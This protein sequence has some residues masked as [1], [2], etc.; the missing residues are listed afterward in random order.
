MET[1]QLFEDIIGLPDAEAKE[2]F[3]RLVG[4]DEIKERLIKEARILLNPELLEEWSK[5]H[6]KKVI[7][8]V[9][10]FQDRASLFI[11]AGDIG[12]GKTTL[13]E[14][15]GD[16]VARQE[17][18][19]VTL[20][21][22]SLNTR[23]R[24]AVGEMTRLISTAFDK[25][26]EVASERSSSGKKPSSAVIFVIDEADAL[27]QS[28]ELDQMHHED[29]AGVNAVIRGIDSLAPAHLPVLIIMCTNRLSAIDPAVMRRAAT[30]F[31]FNRP[32]DEQRM[33]ILRRELAET[34]IK[35]EELSQ[36]AKEMGAKDGKEYGFTYSDI[37][38]KFL[39]TLLLEAFPD[40][41][42]T[43]DAA[44]QILE[45]LLPT[46]PFKKNYANS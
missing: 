16:S 21:R 39:P 15:F 45:R 41:P 23:G 35:D 26:K 14:T 11:F 19:S 34:N 7:P 28:R 42:I 8:I 13:A 5:K 29:R 20:F 37:I 32:N 40:K 44:K 33:E 22:L 9:R 1:D 6:H 38:N 31:E 46:P 17:K 2:R 24:G 12:T 3:E 36:L 18:I 27:T 4:V 30:I 43:F 10:T 25:V